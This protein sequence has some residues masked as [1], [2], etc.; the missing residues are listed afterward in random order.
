MKW[1]YK[2]LIKVVDDDWCARMGCGTCGSQEFRA[3]LISHLK[4][5]KNNSEVLKLE[6]YNKG[7]LISPLYYKLDN[8]LKKQIV[9]EISDE[10]KGLNKVQVDH[11]GPPGKSILSTV[12]YEFTDQSEYLYSL[13]IGTPAGIHLKAMIDHSKRQR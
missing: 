1:L 7:N 9:E 13:I 6:K 5:Y 10:L 11:L 2:Y 4:C 12:F 8:S 3:T